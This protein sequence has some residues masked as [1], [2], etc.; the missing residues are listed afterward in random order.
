MAE[1]QQVIAQSGPLPIKQVVTI[2]TDAP[3]VVTLSGSVWTPD[4]DSMI[5]V[6]LTVD[7]GEFELG[8]RIFSNEPN[9]HRAVVPVIGQYTFEIGEHAFTLTPMTAETTSDANDFFCVTVQY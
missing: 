3:V 1:L 6:L 8:A 4:A 9:E 5:G 2:E 7:R